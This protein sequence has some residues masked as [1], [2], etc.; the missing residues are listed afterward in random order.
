MDKRRHVSFDLSEDLV[1]G[2]AIDAHGT[3]L[4][5][6]T[7]EAA[8]AA[9]AVLFGSVGGPQWDTLPF[10]TRPERGILGLRKGMQLFANL[11]PAKVFDALV[12]ASTLKNE[13]SEEH[14]SELQS[15]M[16]NSYAVFCL[17]KKKK[18]M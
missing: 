16:R 6:E 9:D 10:E 13:R 8:K 4:K 11:R 15:L 18:T 2:A 7:L 3:P 14:T 12:D 1:G 5:E 17:K